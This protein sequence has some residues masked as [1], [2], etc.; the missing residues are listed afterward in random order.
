MKKN[1]VWLI[2]AVTMTIVGNAWGGA[3]SP[4]PGGRS[5]GTQ[6]GGDQDGPLL[7]SDLWGYF[8]GKNEDD[9]IAVFGTEL[10]MPK[11][12]VKDVFGHKQVSKNLVH[13]LPFLTV[14]K[15]LNEWL[16]V[17]VNIDVPF[18]LGSSYEKNREQNDFDTQSLLSLTT[19]NFLV[20]VK[21]TERLSLKFGPSIGIGQVKYQA[22][23][24]VDRNPLPI[25]CD[26]K[27]I[28]TG[29]GW[30]AGLLWQPTKRLRLG[31]QYA[32]KI[33]PDLGGRTVINLGTIGDL[34]QKIK[35]DELVFPQT[36][37]GAFGV[38]LTDKLELVGD[39]SWWEY[40]E[41]PN[42]LS[43]KFP[44]L[45]NLRKP[46]SLEWQDTVGTHI[47]ANYK[48]SKDLLVRAG[49]GWLSQGVPDKRL[50]TITQDVPG[51]DVALGIKYKWLSLAWTHA[52]GQ[53]NAGKGLNRKEYGITID[54]VAISGQIC[55]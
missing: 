9:W 43:L 39:I 11:F 26:T 27:A 53:S 28:G 3:L 29:Y 23:F 30:T 52:W 46:L 1:V 2:V 50:D 51:Y 55:W 31:M 34:R 37:T 33:E 19:V 36:L 45:L 49:I 54:T 35:L 25:L 12:T 15:A 10:V 44:N 22:P 5:S 24:D 17:G 18:R 8:R 48:F 14:G 32:S 4:T 16:A 40:S 20:D 38:M 21:L 47:G 7:T 41:T 42:D 6:I 13:A